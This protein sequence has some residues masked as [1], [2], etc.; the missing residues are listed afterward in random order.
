M[1]SP[2]S[3][4]EFGKTSAVRDNELDAGQCGPNENAVATEC[5]N[6]FFGK[7]RQVEGL[8]V[9]NHSIA[10]WQNNADVMKD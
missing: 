3:V 5:C 6:I 7:N 1:E 2:L 4:I 10:I 8:A 9:P